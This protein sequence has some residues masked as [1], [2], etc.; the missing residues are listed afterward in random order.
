MNHHVRAALG[1]AHRVPI[2]GL[3]LWAIP[4]AA[5]AQN[6]IIQA[7]Q[8]VQNALKILIAIFFVTALFVFGW[9]IVKLMTAASDPKAAKDGKQF[10]FWG[11]IGLFILASLYG[12]IV[13]LQSYF[14]I[15]GGG[16]FTPL[17][18][19]P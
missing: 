15:S 5:F 9:G 6:K 10:I 17:Q 1:A 8:N 14:G 4:A 16:A 11:I 12:I 18:V 13:W 19:N 3:A 7:F 2:V